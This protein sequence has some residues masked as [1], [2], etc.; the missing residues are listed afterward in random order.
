MTWFQKYKWWLLVIMLIVAA[1]LVV[2]WFTRKKNISF[3]FTMGGDMGSILSSLTSRQVQGAASKGLGVYLD[4]PLTTIIN[5]KS[6]AA[7]VLKNLIGSISYNGES[8]LQTNAS[9]TALQSVQVP[10]KSSTPVTDNVQVLVNPSSIKFFSELIKGNQPVVKYDVK[11]T[12][13]GVPY[14]F[15]NSTPIKKS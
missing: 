4:V 1:V 12:L 11:T 9:S 3:D 15:S 14:S 13:F 6:T 10:G 5:N 2:L 7:I 8:I